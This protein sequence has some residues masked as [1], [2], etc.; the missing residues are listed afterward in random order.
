MD[1]LLN[2]KIISC[3]E[4]IRFLKKQETNAAIYTI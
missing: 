1:S 3:K 4:D 2:S